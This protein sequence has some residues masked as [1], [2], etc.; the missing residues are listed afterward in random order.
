MSKKNC[1]TK[2]SPLYQ[3]LKGFTEYESLVDAVYNFIGKDAAEKITSKEQFQSAVEKMYAADYAASTSKKKPL[4]QSTGLSNRPLKEFTPDEVEELRDNIIFLAS[5]DNNLNGG[6][7]GIRE[8][9]NI[10]LDYNYIREE[11]IKHRDDERFADFRDTYD[12][13]L[14]EANLKELITEAQLTLASIDI[15]VDPEMDADIKASELPY[16]ETNLLSNKDRARANAK[17]NVALTMEQTPGNL[18]GLKKFVNF[19]NT[20]QDLSK[21]FADVSITPNKMD[22]FE[23]YM[24]ILKEQGKIKREYRTLRRRLLNGDDNLRTQFTIAFD[25]H[26]TKYHSEAI[27]EMFGGRRGHSKSNF[28]SGN[29]SVG[30]SLTKGWEG[31]FIND[32]IKFDAKGNPSIDNLERLKKTLSKYRELKKA[33]YKASD[34]TPFLEDTLELLA[35]VGIILDTRALNAYLRTHGANSG[36]NDITAL[37]RLYSGEGVEYIFT[38]STTGKNSIESLIENGIDTDQYKRIES[39]MTNEGGVLDLAEIQGRFEIELADN[40]A[41]GPDGKMYQTITAYDYITRQLIDIKNGGDYLQN[42]KEDYNENSVWRKALLD[43]EAAS[44][45]D[46]LWHLSRRHE[47]KDAGVDINHTSEVDE[48]SSRLDNVFRG[49]IPYLTLADKKR[50]YYIK[51]LPDEVIIGKMLDKT[52]PTSV[53]NRFYGYVADEFNSMSKAWEEIAGDEMLSNEELTAGFHYKVHLEDDGKTQTILRRNEKIIRNGKKELFDPL[54][55]ENAPVGDAF[56]ISLVPELRFGNAIAEGLYDEAGKPLPISGPVLT[57][58]GNLSSAHEGFFNIIEEPLRNALEA[59]I[60]KTA[61]KIYKDLFHIEYEVKDDGETKAKID[62]ASVSS[63]IWEEYLKDT[64]VDENGYADLDGLRDA[65]YLMAMRY[66][67]N[68]MSA[69]IEYTK[70]FT[71]DPRTYKS[72]SDFWK[73][74]PAGSATGTSMRIFTGKDGEIKVREH[75]KIAIAKNIIKPSEYL[76]D[77]EPVIE[78]VTA[79]LDPV[80][81]KD[82]IKRLTESVKKTLA[83]YEK[84]NVTDAQAWITMDRFREI[85]RGVGDWSTGMDEAFNRIKN[86]KGKPEDYEMFR[87]QMTTMQPRKGMHYEL[88]NRN[89]RMIPVYLKYSQAVLFPDFIASSRQLTEI[90]EAME[91]AGVDELVVEDGIKVGATSAIN[92]ENNENMAT[93]FKDRAITLS[94]TKWKL[95]QELPTKGD[96]NSL[97]GTQIRKNILADI[98]D[99][100]NYAGMSGKQ[101]KT[102]LHRMDATLSDRG[103]QKVKDKFN[104]NDDGTM[105]NLDGVYSYLIEELERE[106]EDAHVIK[107]LKAKM[108]IDSILSHRHKLLSKILAYFNKYTVKLKQHGGSAIQMSDFGMESG[109]NMEEYK[110]IRDKYG[111]GITW[112]TNDLKPKPMRIEYEYDNEGNKTGVKHFEGEVILPYKRVAG[113]FGD[114]WESLKAE[115]I[116]KKDFTIITNRIDDEALNLIGYRIPNQKLASS[117]SLKVIGIMPPEAGDTV[118]AYSEITTQTGSDFD[119]DKMFFFYPS[120]TKKKGRIVKVQYMDDSNSTALDRTKAMFSDPNSIR[121]LLSLVTDKE[122]RDSI[123]NAVDTINGKIDSAIKEK[124]SLLAGE[125]QDMEEINMTLQAIESIKA[126]L[127]K[128]NKDKL[129]LFDLYAGLNQLIYDEIGQE[130]G[131]YLDQKEAMFQKVSQHLEGLPMEQQ[132]TTAALQSRRV[133]LYKTVLESPHSYIRAISTVDSDWLKDHINMMLPD[134]GLSGIGMFSGRTQMR[135][136]REFIAS[137]GGVGQIANHQSDHALSQ[138]SGKYINDPAH[139]ISDGRI[140]LDNIYSSEFENIIPSGNNFKVESVN[141]HYYITEAISAYMNAFVDAAKDNYIGRAN[142]NAMT[143]NPALLLIRAG[144]SPQFVNAFMSQPIVKRFVELSQI[145]QGQAVPNTVIDPLEQALNEFGKEISDLNHEVKLNRERFTTPKLMKAI[146]DYNTTKSLTAEQIQDQVDLLSLFKYTQERAKNLRKSMISSKSDVDGAGSS[147]T[148]AII[149]KNLRENVE[150]EVDDYGVPYVQNYDEI[151]RQLDEEG[152]PFDT[153]TGAAYNNSIMAVIKAIGPHTIEGTEG[154]QM[155]VND[156][157]NKL[158]GKYPED[159]QKARKIFQLAYASILA[160]KLPVLDVGISNDDK[161]GLGQLMRGKSSLAKRLLKMRKNYRYNRN[162]LIRMLEPKLGS[163]GG[164][165]YIGIDNSRGRNANVDKRLRSDWMDLY[166]SDNI[167]DRKFAIDLIIYAFYTSALADNISTIYRLIPPTVLRDLGLNQNLFNEIRSSLSKENVSN[168]IPQV[169][170]E[171]LRNSWTDTSIVPK[172]Y[173][174]KTKQLIG[175]DEKGRK[176]KSGTSLIFE[177]DPSNNKHLVVGWTEATEESEAQP[178]F[179]PYVT[180]DVPRKSKMTGEYLTKKKDGSKIMDTQLFQYIGNRESQN[181]KTGEVK[182]MGVYA[183]VNKLGESN[184]ANKLFE[185]TVGKSKTSIVKG[186]NITLEQQ[187]LRDSWV[188]VAKAKYPGNRDTGEQNIS[189]TNEPTTPTEDKIAENVTPSATGGIGFDFAEVPLPDQ[190][191]DDV[192]QQMEEENED[193]N[194]KCN[195]KGGT[196]KAK[197]GAQFGFTPGSKWRIIKNFKGKSHDQGGIDINISK[198][199][200]KMSRKNG[201]FEAKNGVVINSKSLNNG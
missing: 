26:K 167:G 30:K 71:G 145:Q 127:K 166:N 171:V 24:D 143:N 5:W 184:G 11:L 25:N 99:D 103:L 200:I 68:I 174:N 98:E 84:V 75:Y 147:L 21:L 188:N 3:R 85:L 140:M 128:S 87:K 88:V 52:I 22:L 93:E 38:E 168:L 133:D 181:P 185:F 43:K 121:N 176:L 63:M 122:T 49:L 150:L 148:G 62:Y 134:E 164:L 165:D 152:N 114:E 190:I 144:Y 90:A 163:Y 6:L 16:I 197:D 172:V 132:N 53:M 201:N 105:D 7:G 45:I 146:K 138:G 191:P 92:I 193:L 58:T 120:I 81:D 51:G 158:Y 74:T 27:N 4:R 130:L 108:P 40:T 28:D 100:K 189:E 159:E 196:P 33:I 155:I 46:L 95:Q 162:A 91:K 175:R 118:V 10:N 37:Q 64:V 161:N 9:E 61:D 41:F 65:A 104:I 94:N 135:L 77:P 194:R 89:G 67:L 12:I 34:A 17:L 97:I 54:L 125:D 142:F 50:L 139:R 137:Q 177:M 126:K 153:L 170:R 115:A 72:T 32:L 178:I 60:Q 31:S 96:K 149:A 160:E 179:K 182:L 141:K 36:A 35:S 23:H 113:L 192:R 123:L 124:K 44:E 154:M 66:E 129:E 183:R 18:L 109:A 56:S 173:Y 15:K 57:D 78:Y 14:K 69:N 136:R 187:E 48:F 73:R 80:K 131:F 195:G 157:Y 47:G 55:P 86:K 1:I 13:I 29:N 110:N 107:A 117:G 119:I 82:E 19:G 83:S 111:K 116:R 2:G 199:G 76:N 39:P 42:I 70:L 186:N 20:W 198:D 112:L 106:G 169:T 8:I 79:H 102:A 180:K 101:L 151:F 59:E 156:I